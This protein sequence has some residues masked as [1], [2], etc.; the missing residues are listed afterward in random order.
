[1][2]IWKF[3]KACGIPEGRD[4]ERNPIMM[5]RIGLM[6]RERSAGHVVQRKYH[7][8]LKTDQFYLFCRAFRYVTPWK[9][10]EIF[11]KQLSS[12]VLWYDM[13]LTRCCSTFVG[14]ITKQVY[15]YSCAVNLE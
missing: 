3:F 6:K 9:K 15:S 7:A 14:N 10:A 1:M 13:Q 8:K 5:D 11:F 2:S 12:T 4:F